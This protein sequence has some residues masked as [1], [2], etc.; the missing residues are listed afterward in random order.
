LPGLLFS[1]SCTRKSEFCLLPE[2]CGARPNWTGTGSV[3]FHYRSYILHADKVTYNRLT[4]ELE[5]EGH[6]QVAGGPND[7]LINADHGDMQL[8]MHTGRFYKVT[9]SQGRAFRRPLRRV[10]HRQPFPVFGAACSSRPA[11]ATTA[12]STAP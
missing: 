10:F 11:R 5:A 3:E 7:V 8:N 4:T 1:D 12:L 6:V 9:G 2:P